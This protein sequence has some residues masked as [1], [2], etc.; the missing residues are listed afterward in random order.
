M[1]T[2]TPFQLII[3]QARS[4]LL[5]AA[6]HETGRE[7][8]KLLAAELVEGQKAVKRLEDIYDELEEGRAQATSNG[9]LQEELRVARAERDY[10]EAHFDAF[11]HQLTVLQIQ[12]EFGSAKL[13]KSIAWAR[14]E[15][16]A[17]DAP[18]SNGNDPNP[19]DPQE[20]HETAG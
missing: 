18:G 8:I 7:A 12:P 4:A 9:H 16:T 14:E 1:E 3:R 2:L 13:P 5:S 17:E 10:Y 6:D 15:A 11:L 20:R 19:P